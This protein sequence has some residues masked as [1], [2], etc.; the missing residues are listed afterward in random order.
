M[1]SPCSNLWKS[2]AIPYLMRVNKFLNNHSQCEDSKGNILRHFVSLAF[3]SSNSVLTMVQVL[4]FQI[5]CRCESIGLF[6]NTVTW[7]KFI[8]DAS[9]C[10]GL[11]DGSDALERCKDI[12]SLA[13]C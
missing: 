4:L 6:P 1:F 8:H 11:G 3:L 12:E 7:A 9:R 2:C 5:S 10:T 13:G